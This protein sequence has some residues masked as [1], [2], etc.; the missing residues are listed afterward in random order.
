M[1]RLIS[2]LVTSSVVLVT[3][4]AFAEVRLPAFFGDGVVLQQRTPVPV[5]GFADPGEQVTV[6][7]S[8]QTRKAKADSGGRWTVR[9]DPLAPGGPLEMTV[10]GKN[11][12][13]TRNILVG[14]VWIAAG[15]SN[16]E[17]PVRES[18][19]AKVERSAAH[20]PPTPTLP[21]HPPFP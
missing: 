16:M 13:T 3:A 15:Q 20:F 2:A 6:T 21:P 5:W 7:L 1:M 8:G 19:N 14:E 9:L 10:A 11:T 12:I 17:W 18:A 4:S